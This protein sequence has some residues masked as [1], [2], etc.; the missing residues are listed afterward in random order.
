MLALSDDNVWAVGYTNPDGLGL[1][2]H[3]DGVGWQQWISPTGMRHTTLWS[4]SASS[5]TD[6]WAVGNVDSDPAILHFDGSQWTVIPSASPAQG[7]S[8]QA[9]STLTRSNAWAVG[10]S[11]TTSNDGHQPN[12]LIEHWNG[13]AWTVS[14]TAAT[15]GILWGVSAIAT[16]DVWAAGQAQIALGNGGYA[17]APLIMHWNGTSWNQVAD[18]EQPNSWLDNVSASSANDVWMVGGAGFL[19]WNGRTWAVVP[20]PVGGAIRG[21][22]ALSANDA[23]AVGNAAENALVE[24]WNGSTWTVVSS[25]TEGVTYLNAVA[26]DSNDAHIWVGG[27][28]T[29]GTAV[30]GLIEEA[31]QA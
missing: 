6:V 16:N 25:K 17:I 2:L 24:H 14:P 11:V 29:P 27:F 15:P 18:T 26:A 7:N 19:H 23:W 4:L 1:I 28:D 21:V 5:P 9:V 8:L 12:A 31:C 22:L 30:R 3:W 10:A 13:K 20:N